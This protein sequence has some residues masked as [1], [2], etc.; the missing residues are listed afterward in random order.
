MESFNQQDLTSNVVND[1]S[2]DINIDCFSKYSDQTIE[3]IGKYLE[4]FSDNLTDLQRYKL[5]MILNP[6]N[7]S[8]PRDLSDIFHEYVGEFIHQHLCSGKTNTNI[9]SHDFL[10]NFITLVKDYQNA[11][12]QTF[13]L[14]FSRFNIPFSFYSTTP[15]HETYI[16]QNYQQYLLHFNNLTVSISSNQI[17]PIINKFQLFSYEAYFLIFYSVFIDVT[18]I[19]PFALDYPTIQRLSMDDFEIVPPVVLDDPQFIKI[20]HLY[21]DP[22]HNK[23][24]FPVANYSY[25]LMQSLISLIRYDVDYLIFPSYANIDDI[26]S[27]KNLVENLAVNCKVIK[28]DNYFNAYSLFITIFSKLDMNIDVNLISSY[29]KSEVEV[30]SPTVYE[31]DYLARN[32]HKIVASMLSYI[33]DNHELVKKVHNDKDGY[34]S[35]VNI[36]ADNA[37]LFNSDQIIYEHAGVTL[38]SDKII[39]AP[40]FKVSIKKVRVD[41]KFSKQT[42]AINKSFNYSDG[43]LVEISIIQREKSPYI[44]ALGCYKYIGLYYYEFLDHSISQEVRLNT[45]VLTTNEYENFDH[46]R[47]TQGVELFN[48][49]KFS[50]MYF[51]P[52]YD[53]LTSDIKQR[54]G[55]F[56]T[57]DDEIAA[58]HKSHIV[59][60]L[61]SFTGFSKNAKSELLDVGMQIRSPVQKFF[62]YYF[63]NNILTPFKKYLMTYHS[64]NNTCHTIVSLQRRLGTVF[65]S[66]TCTTCSYCGS[67]H[68]CDRD[69]NLCF[70]YHKTLNY[71]DINGKFYNIFVPNSLYSTSTSQFDL[72]TFTIPKGFSGISVKSIINN[73]DQ[74]GFSL[75]KSNRVS[76]VLIR[77]DRIKYQFDTN[78]KMFKVS[79]LIEKCLVNVPNQ[80]PEVYHFKPYILEESVNYETNQ[81]IA[82][83]VEYYVNLNYELDKREN[84]SPYKSQKHKKETEN[85]GSTDKSKNIHKQLKNNNIRDRKRSS[86]NSSNEYVVISKDKDVPPTI[87]E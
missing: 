53:Q 20:N 69:Q 77:T 86:S 72:V 71:C 81:Q 40:N 68:I 79:D 80:S 3:S 30:D 19:P 63:I 4:R 54:F 14:L 36:A 50:Q 35:T 10:F 66:T 13:N 16:S 22:H 9:Y 59:G 76:M 64:S 60:L 57:N 42:H 7:I 18:T 41:N 34:I 43:R 17:P 2:L 28:I 46:N 8:R 58:Y 23:L 55:K 83:R 25:P 26:V 49:N 51:N 37:H 1:D 39:K 67:I 29:F 65:G 48:E 75:F 27:I 78:A 85:S 21:N 52:T 38:V 70:Q 62:K 74:Y 47:L 6:Y 12:Y 5:N 87:T 82:N 84:R 33:K 44:I 11:N 56:I 61:G 45:F 24:V 31:S 32:S 73:V 15:K